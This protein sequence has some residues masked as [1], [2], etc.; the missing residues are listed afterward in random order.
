MTITEL[1]E[2]YRKLRDSKVEDQGEHVIKPPE[3]FGDSLRTL[4]YNIVR[5]ISPMLKERFE[6]CSSW[7]N[8]YLGYYWLSAKQI[9]HW[10]NNQTAR[11]WVD[12]RAENAYDVDC[13]TKYPAKNIALLAYD[14]YYPNEMYLVWDEGHIEPKVWMYFDADYYTFNSFE[15]FLLH[16]NGFINDEDTVREYI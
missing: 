5:P 7:D 3:P 9:N 16:I 8:A 2:N 12:L 1:L 11:E 4:D 10:Q 13:F 15:R 14:P 6:F